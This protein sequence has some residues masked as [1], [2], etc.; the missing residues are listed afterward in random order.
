MFY[1]III[2]NSIGED[3]VWYFS[4]LMDVFFVF[5]GFFQKMSD[6]DF[7]LFVR[8][9]EWGNDG[10]YYVG[11]WGYYK[12]IGEDRLCDYVVFVVY[13]FYWFLLIFIQLCDDKIDEIFFLMGDFWRVYV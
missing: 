3:V 5:C 11:K 6:D 9:N 8:C 10:L 4:D 1:V 13:K 12:K 2:V 7:Y